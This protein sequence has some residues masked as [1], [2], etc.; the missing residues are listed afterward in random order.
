MQSAKAFA[1]ICAALICGM[2]AATFMPGCQ[3]SAPPPAPVPSATSGGSL[4]TDGDEPAAVEAPVPIEGPAAP[5]SDKP[6]ENSPPPA[7]PEETPEQ[8]AAA[9]KVGEG[10]PV[11]AAGEW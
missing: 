11:L 2:V 9:R 1:A 6:V 10:N 4:T 3:P 7:V 5:T 8:A